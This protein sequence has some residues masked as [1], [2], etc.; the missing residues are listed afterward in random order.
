MFLIDRTSEVL[1]T[2]GCPNKLALNDW[3][4]EFKGADNG[5]PCTHCDIGSYYG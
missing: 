1:R 5:F 4:R 3:M 2:L